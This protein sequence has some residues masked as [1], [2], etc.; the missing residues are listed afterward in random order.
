MGNLLLKM[1]IEPME[2]GN[3]NFELVELI[4]GKPHCKNHG[5]MLK[6]SQHGFWRCIRAKPLDP[7][8]LTEEYEGDCRAGC[9]ED[10]I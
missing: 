10:E 1:N 7:N 4:N 9:I 8:N 5:A 6:V 2:D 3:S